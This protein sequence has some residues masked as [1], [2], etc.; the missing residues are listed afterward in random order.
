MLRRFLR[1]T[2]ETV[3]SLKG[4]IILDVGCGNG[5]LDRL[6]GEAGARVVAM[7]MSRSIE[8]ASRSIISEQVFFIQGD[9]QFPPIEPA[10]MDLVHCSGV[11]IHTNDTKHSFFKIEKTVKNDGKLSVW[12]YHP[13]RDPIHRFFTFL[14]SYTSK[15]PLGVQYGLYL[16]TLLPISFIIKR[17]KGNKQ[18]RREM[19]VD[20][21][22]W[23][24][25]EH[26]WEHRPEEVANWFREAGYSTI[27][28]T[29][30]EVFGYNTTGVKDSDPAGRQSGT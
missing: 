1:E 15:L 22:D 26:R 4:K 21:L 30:V 18:N 9:L 13:R 5:V 14:R 3:A 17:L 23:F 20:I 7:D 28:K 10:C 2:V 24:T 6:I 11:L 8:Q 25:P 19:M 12:V 16:F 27:Q 29:T